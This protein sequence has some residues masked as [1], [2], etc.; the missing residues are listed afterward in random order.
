M[1]AGGQEFEPPILHQFEILIVKTARNGGFYVKWVQ[2]GYKVRDLWLKKT[3]ISGGL[4]L[5][6]FRLPPLVTAA[7]TPPV[8]K[9]CRSGRSKLHSFYT[10]L[11][12]SWAYLDP[13][14][15][16]CQKIH[17]ITPSA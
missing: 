3:P 1:Q 17:T 7:L 15:A 16:T 12:A 6:K 13:D 9:N 5:F 4:K 8:G 14:N 11:S 2:S 10:I